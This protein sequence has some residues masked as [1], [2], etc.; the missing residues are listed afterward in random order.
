MVLVLIAMDFYQIKNLCKE[1]LISR[2]RELDW[3][4]NFV[5][6]NFSMAAEISWRLNLG[7]NIPKEA[8]KETIFWKE[9]HW[10]SYASTNLKKNWN[11]KDVQWGK[12]LLEM[13]KPNF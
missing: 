12:T 11:R 5:W 3:L 4:K 9:Y 10:W 7:L 1:A 13:K 6:L 2:E 8:L